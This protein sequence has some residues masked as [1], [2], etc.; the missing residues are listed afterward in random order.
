[1]ETAKVKARKTLLGFIILGV[2]GVFLASVFVAIYLAQSIIVSFDIDKETAILYRLGA[3]L[4]CV[5][6]WGAVAWN[7]YTNAI[8]LSEFMDKQYP[9]TE[10]K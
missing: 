5:V 2:G 1:M 4:T 7:D 3:I 10:E 9:K 8:K 6:F